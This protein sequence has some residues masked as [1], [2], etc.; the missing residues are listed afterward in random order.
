VTRVLA[1]DLGTSSARA[2]LCDERG[3]DVAGAEAQVH[4]SETRGHSG[5]LGEFDPDELVEVVREAVDE[6]R[7]ESG[8][9]DA[10]ATSCFWHSLLA[11]DGRGRPLTAVS[12]WR[13]TRAAG[14]ADEL[15]AR[16]DGADVHRRTGCPLHPSF[17]PARLLRLRREEPDVFRSAARFLSFP[18]YL[19]QRLAGEARAS[20]SMVSATG[21]W[22]VEGGWD[23]ELLAE[24]GIEPQ[25]LPEVSDEPAGGDV[26]WFAA[27]GDGACANVGAGCVTRDR[28]ALTVGTSAAYRIV[29]EGDGVE[30]RPGLFLFRVD[31]R[32]VVEGGSLSDG[33]NLWDWLERTLADVDAEGLA[34]E[35]ADGH[36]LTFLA[37]LGG[38][39]SPGWDG[40]VRGAVAGL[41][42]HTGPRELVHAA[43]EGV[44]CRVADVADLVPEVHEV[45]VTGAALH[46]NRDWLQIVA[47]V[48]GRPLRVSG[49][50]EASARGAAVLALEHLG[51]TPEPAPLAEEVPSREDRSA[52]Y[53]LA[54]RRQSALYDAIARAPLRR[55]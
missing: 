28:A 9:I 48:L 52:I 32:R 6:A 3:R 42:Y 38:E 49:V 1:L 15:A 43:L 45:V 46:K 12:T 55:E 21:L 13:D 8:P 16:L 36:G 14:D 50:A 4:Y 33:G 26:P 31:E 29:Y 25:R 44:A 40:R 23:E 35:P 11:V 2:R 10:V 34:D 7:R 54:R 30:P 18:D 5:R 27:W 19:L 51:K 24:L 53:R 20:L 47:D 17:W 39:R 22:R 41:S 37:L